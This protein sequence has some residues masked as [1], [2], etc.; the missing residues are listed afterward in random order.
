MP[1]KN[2]KSKIPTDKKRDL[3]YEIYVFKKK[4]KRSLDKHRG[5]GGI[6]DI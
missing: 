2:S 5:G 3:K 6:I 4:N 1:P